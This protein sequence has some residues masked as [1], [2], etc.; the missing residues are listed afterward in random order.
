[1]SQAPAFLSTVGCCSI[2]AYKA[3]PRRLS[4]TASP[5]EPT[6]HP[7]PAQKASLTPVRRESGHCSGMWIFHAV[8]CSNS[9]SNSGGTVIVITDGPPLK[10]DH[11]GTNNFQ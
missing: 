1:M 4:E 8:A 10:P 2:R 5:D 6:G 11:Q 7:R 9:A 3:K